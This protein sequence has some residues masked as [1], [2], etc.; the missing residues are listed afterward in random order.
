MSGGW[1][2]L[3]YFGTKW[4][5]FIYSLLDGRNSQNCWNFSL[6]TKGRNVLESAVTLPER[7]RQ[8]K[9]HV[10]KS[11]KR[12]G[13]LHA[14]VGEVGFELVMSHG[15]I[16]VS[17]EREIWSMIPESWR[18]EWHWNGAWGRHMED[19][20]IQTENLGFTPLCGQL[21]EVLRAVFRK[22][23]PAWCVGRFWLEKQEAGNM[24]GRWFKM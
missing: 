24:V 9:Q 11:Q 6:Y 17:Q 22:D 7:K 19:S 1:L 18:E 14:V 5:K 20:S 4:L 13:N 16:G 10:Q 2:S 8:D 15:D 12:Q 23:T 21:V 3:N